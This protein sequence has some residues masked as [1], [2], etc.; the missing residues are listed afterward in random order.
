[1]YATKAR[2]GAASDTLNMY[3]V[4]KYFGRL[5][6]DMVRAAS[7]I[8]AFYAG[9]IFFRVCAHFCNQLRTCEFWSRCGKFIT[10]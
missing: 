10:F 4:K 1:M 3:A 9:V 6:S 2:L 5:K 8:S 7:L